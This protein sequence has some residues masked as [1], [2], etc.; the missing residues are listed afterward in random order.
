[1]RSKK[2]KVTARYLKNGAVHLLVEFNDGTCHV[3]GWGRD[4]RT[5]V[6]HARYVRPL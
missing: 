5:A 4:F 2:P 3:N 1:M 6:I